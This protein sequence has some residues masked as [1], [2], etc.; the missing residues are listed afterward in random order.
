[1]ARASAGFNAQCVTL[2]FVCSFVIVP[3]RYGT[4]RLI[5]MPKAEGWSQTALH[6]EPQGREPLQ[7]KCCCVERMAAAS[8]SRER[9]CMV[10]V[11]YHKRLTSLNPEADAIT[12]L[13]HHGYAIAK[14]KAARLLQQA[15]YAAHNLLSLSFHT[16]FT[17]SMN[18]LICFF[19]ESC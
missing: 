8:I 18:A 1:M 9:M 6:S 7:V 15:R 13:P 3:A 16:P 11:P 10:C 5:R 4:A 12:V 2:H 17:L 19:V 14:H